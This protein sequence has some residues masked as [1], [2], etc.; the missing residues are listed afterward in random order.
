MGQVTKVRLSCYLVLLSNDS[1]TR[2][3]DSHTFVTWPIC[4]NKVGHQLIHIWLF[5]SWTV[6]M[7]SEI[8]N[9]TMHKIWNKTM[10]RH[11]HSLKCIW[12]VVY[13]MV[14]TMLRSPCVNSAPRGQNGHHFADDRLKRDSMNEKFFISI[15]ILLKCVPKG[16]IDKKVSIG[17]GN[18]LVPIRWQAINSTNAD[19]V[20][21]CI[22]P[23]L[24]EKLLTH[25]GRVTHICVSKLPIIGSDNGLSPGRRQAIIWTIAGILLIGPLETNFSEILIRIQTFS[26]KKNAFENIVCEM[27]GILSRP[28]CVNAL[29]FN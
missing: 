11:P 3:Q 12:K 24:R 14:I 25:L 18:G 1:K 16:P 28:R 13:S 23:A 4:G 15:Q 10:Q 21:R 19:P 6:R 2:Y 7:N 9:K 27:V 8:S 20:H 22:Y 5:I 26:F 17:P 29:I